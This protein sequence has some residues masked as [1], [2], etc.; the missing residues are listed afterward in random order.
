MSN[1]FLKLLNMSFAASWLIVTVIILRLIAR[2]TPKWIICLLWGLVAIRLICPLS[3]KSSFGV[4]PSD[5][6][7][8]KSILSESHHKLNITTGVEPLDAM[9]NEYL[10]DTYNGGTSVVYDYGNI[11]MSRLGVIWICGVFGLLLYA[12]IVNLRLRGHL[13]EAILLQEKIYLCDYV[14]SPFIFG[15]FCPYIYLP[16]GIDES[17]MEYV[18]AHEKVHLQRKDHIWKMI[19]FL[20]LA[21]YWFNPLSWAAFILF[22][23]DIELACDE[24]VIKN[25]SVAEKKAYLES[26]L[27]CS[28]KKRIA[29][30]YPLEFGEVGVKQRVKYILHYKKPTFAVILLSFLAFTVIGI[31][32]LTNALREEQTM[33]MIP[34]D[35]SPTQIQI[36]KKENE[37]EQILLDYYKENIVEVSVLLQDFDNAVTS[38]NILVVSEEKNTDVDEQNNMTAF[39]SEYLNLDA[40]NINLEYVDSETFSL[41]K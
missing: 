6:V 28:F 19:A 16:S 10:E 12:V 20:I 22:C 33:V 13:K 8:P 38:A 4:V 23:R 2:K 29:I 3:I 32:F 15:F 21:I 14:C 30:V 17:D 24:K 9:V 27:T 18:I 34:T 35:A 39:V 7:I 41:Y 31:C 1:I 5:E 26:L 40:H 25:L 11:L 37:L 36:H